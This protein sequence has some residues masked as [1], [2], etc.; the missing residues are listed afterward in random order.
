MSC[1]SRNIKI[2]VET[3]QHIIDTMTKE[4]TPGT[5]SPRDVFYEV[6][7]SVTLGT[8]SYY[9][10]LIDAM[11]GMYRYRMISSCDVDYWVQC[12]KDKAKLVIERY[13]PV[14]TAYVTAV[15]S[16]LADELTEVITST[17]SEDIPSSGLISGSTYIDTRISQTV[18]SKHYGGLT[19]KSLD[20]LRSSSRNP[21]EQFAAEFT[22][23][24]IPLTG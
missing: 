10:K 16:E 14:F 6:V 11:W 7:K 3:P 19:A 23:W 22:A 15:R 2:E 21:Y 8:E 9:Q 1:C 17:E 4:Y 13:T 18:T 24:F 12:M 20:D 5:P